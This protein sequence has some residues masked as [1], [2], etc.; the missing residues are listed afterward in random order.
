MKILFLLLMMLSKSVLAQNGEDQFPI[1][2]TMLSCV[3]THR[4][5]PGVNSLR[6]FRLS[7][8]AFYSGNSGTNEAWS[9][10][11]VSSVWIVANSSANQI[12]LNRVSGLIFIFD[13]PKNS[14]SIPIFTGTCKKVNT[15]F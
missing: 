1:K 3:G 9:V 7:K 14:Q 13:L 10:D 11:W 2:E 6:H 8:Y 4:D 15:L 5:N 12:Q